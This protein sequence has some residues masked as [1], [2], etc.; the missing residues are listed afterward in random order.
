[1][2]DRV[3][4]APTLSHDPSID[5]THAEGLTSSQIECLPDS[6]YSEACEVECVCDEKVKV[7]QRIKTLAC[8][9]VFHSKCIIRLLFRS[10]K[11]P[12]D[13]I[14]ALE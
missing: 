3:G 14:Q 1:M 5:Y 12:F 7:G 4:P 2:E 10:N 8:G 9:H 11:C 6:V 13:S